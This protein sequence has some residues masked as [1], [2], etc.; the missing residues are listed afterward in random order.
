MDGSNT[1][2]STPVR[3]LL[4]ALLASSSSAF[5][6]TVSSR[7]RNL[8]F[9]STSLNSAVSINPS[10]VVSKYE[11]QMEK[12]AEK[13]K[14]SS[15]LSKDDLKV[16]HNDD[17]I[18]VVEKPSGILCVPD[19]ANNPSLNAAVFAAH[20]NESNDMSKMAVHRLGMDTSGLVVF[21]KSDAALRL[22]NAQFR[23]RK[24]TRKYEALVCGSLEGEGEIDLPLMRDFENPPFM[25]VS[26]DDAQK[27]LIGVS[28][29]DLPGG[30][31]K[32][33]EMPKPSLTKYKVIGSEELG[34]HPVTRVELESVSGRTHQLNVHCAAIGHPIVKDAVYGV[35][36]EAAKSGGVDADGVSEDV[37]KAINA[38]A[39]GGMCVHMKE[40]SFSHPITREEMKFESK[41]PF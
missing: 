35:D 5:T 38:A 14:T 13:D 24:V 36:G 2:R 20:P 18:I 37:Q 4:L 22:L 16:L 28:K 11:A 9:A 29:D 30:L 8:S 17:D 15:A 23:A 26:T 31:K 7:T 6:G 40:L 1:R 21:A 41:S 10:D 25:R 12:M 32:I 34:G 39:S 33:L 27:A 19:K 3:L